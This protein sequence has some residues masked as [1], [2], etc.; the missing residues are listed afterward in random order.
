M[1]LVNERDRVLGEL[2]E[3]LLKAVQTARERLED[4]CQTPIKFV[5]PSS[6]K[7]ESPSA[8]FFDDAHF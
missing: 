6:M 3:Q 5:A 7:G 2:E 4:E 1:Q 8:L